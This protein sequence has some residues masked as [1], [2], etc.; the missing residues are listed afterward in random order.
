MRQQRGW[1]ERGER[2]YDLKITTSRDDE[3]EDDFGEGDDGGGG[4]GGGDDGGKSG[5]VLGFLT[6][7]ELLE[8]GSIR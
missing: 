1:R 3:G 6:G 7:E 2:K 4:G 8:I 5:G